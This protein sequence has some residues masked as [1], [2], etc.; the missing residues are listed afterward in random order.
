M[1][2]NRYRILTIAL[3][4][5]LIAAFCVDCY[6]E[7]NGGQ[8]SL[9]GVKLIT[10]QVNCSKLAKQVGLDREEIRKSIT[11]QLEDAGIKVVRP[12][13][14]SSLPGRC[15]LRVS[16]NV[17]KPQHLDTF[18]YNLKVEFVQA[19]TLARLPETKIDATTWNRTWSA[20]F[21][22]ARRR[23]A[24]QTAVFVRD[25]CQANPVA[26]ENP[27]PNKIDKSPQASAATEAGFIASKGSDVFHKTDCRWAQNISADNLVTYESR[28][29]AIEDGKR[30][31]KWCKP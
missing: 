28:K 15:R 24:L 26:N 25:H 19:V 5:C 27:D 11:S 12:Q 16:I 8:Q 29:E 22:G 18:M 10:V 20:A 4:T 23:E 7:L 13:I 9:E 30:P 1:T 14:W 17:Y 3:T 21:P 6:G 31:C 2:G